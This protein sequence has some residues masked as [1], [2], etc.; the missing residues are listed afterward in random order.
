M[1]TSP[2]APSAEF[3]IYARLNDFLPAERRQRALAYR[4]TGTPSVKDAI[5]AIGVPHAEVDVVVVDGEPVDFRRRLRGGERVAVYP[6]FA[7]LDLPGVLRLRATP[8]GPP[9]FV[10]DVHLGRLARHLRLLGFDALYRTDYDDATIVSIAR[11]E[12]RV[13]LTRDRALLKHGAVASGHWLRA[14][15]P[16][17]QLE[18]VVRAFDLADQFRPFTRCLRCNDLLQRVT[19]DEIAGRLPPRVEGGFDDFVRCRGCGNVYWR[20]THYERLQRI[21]AATAL[22]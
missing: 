13:V 3:R 6:A 22:L 8:T 12:S 2:N 7:A 9:R 15:D 16:R 20:G 10:L 18:E 4:F 5:E 17:R 11:D 19:K 1:S 14:T 21:V